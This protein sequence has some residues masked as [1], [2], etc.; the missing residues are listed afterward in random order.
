MSIYIL[1]IFFNA[2]YLYI[3][4]WLREHIVN[5]M[6]GEKAGELILGKSEGRNQTATGCAS[7]FASRNLLTAYEWIH[8]RLI[9]LDEVIKVQICLVFMPS[10]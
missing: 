5:I 6:A 1:Y 7:N 8:S 10:I 3:F 9:M 2:K 4:C